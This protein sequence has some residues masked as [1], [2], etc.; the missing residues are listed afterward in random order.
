MRLAGIIGL[1]ITASVSMPNLTV[2]DTS[3]PLDHQRSHSVPQRR[4]TFGRR[5]FDTFRLTFRQPSA[6]IPASMLP[7]KGA[8]KPGSTSTPFPGSDK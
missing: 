4:G 3:S 2:V 6:P 1:P 8:A 7:E 5:F